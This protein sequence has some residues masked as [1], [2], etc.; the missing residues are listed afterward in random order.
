MYRL[1]VLLLIIVGTLRIGALAQMPIIAKPCD[2][3]QDPAKFTNQIVQVRATVSIA[4]ESF[5]LKALGCD[6]E[7]DARPIWLVYGGD[8]PTPIASTVNDNSRPAGMVLKVDGRPITLHRDAALDLFVRRLAAERTTDVTGGKCYYGC[9]LY[10]VEATLTGVFFAAPKGFPGGGYGHLGC[11][12]LL[13]IQQVSDVSAV[14]TPVPAGGRYECSTKTWNIGATEASEISATRGQC[15]GPSACRQAAFNE[16]AAVADHWG[17]HI[18]FTDSDQLMGFPDLVW[19]AGDMLTTYNLKTAFQDTAHQSGRITGMTALRTA[20]EAVSPPL[21]QDTPVGCR[22]V[23]SVFA[24][25]V[26]AVATADGANGGQ[27]L[28]GSTEQVANQALQEA[29]SIWKVTANPDITFAGCDKPFMYEGNQ[30]S[31][32]YWR[33][34]DGMQTFMVQITQFGQLRHGE[35]WDSAPWVLSRGN[36][37]VCTAE[38]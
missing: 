25:T 20:C 34:P 2:L 33:D 12:H 24:K 16:I 23:N 14:R 35:N 8:E 30:F 22:A 11:C 37:L 27:L 38:R 13:A 28:V 10:V 1:I 17:D 32:C 19:R 6:E 7:K 36:G 31:W 5:T 4:F 21:P 3:L 15:A 18:S 26:Q 9:R 29:T